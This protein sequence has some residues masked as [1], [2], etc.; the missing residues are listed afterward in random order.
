VV[1]V[2]AFAALAFAVAS[3]GRVVTVASTESAAPP[4][5][6]V[7]V[8]PGETLWQIARDIAPDVDPRITVGRIIEIN[9]LDSV[10]VR[11]GQQV[12]VPVG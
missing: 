8:E 5:D 6:T 9:G 10:Q 4:R 11:V 7:V 2:I 1:A 3:L 12:L